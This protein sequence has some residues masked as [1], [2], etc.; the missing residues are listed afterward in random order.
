MERLN[1][2]NAAQLP[3]SVRRPR[4]DMAALQIGMAHIGAGAFHRCHQAEYTDDMLE[5]SFGPWGVLGVNLRPPRLAEILSPQDN[6]YT[7]TLK[8][9][10]VAETRLIG[11]VRRVLDVETPAEAGMAIAALSAPQIGV[12]TLTLTERGYCHIPA[13]GDLDTANPDVRN[14]LETPAQ[15][16]SALG[17]LAAV[18]ERRRAIAAPALTIISCDNLPANGRLLHRVLMQFIAPRGPALSRWIDDHV[19]FP[20]AMV[21]RIVPATSSDDLEANAAHLGMLDQAAVFGEPF[22]QWVIEDRFAGVKPPWHL[23]G[24]Q[25]VADVEPYELIKMRVL[26]AAQSTLSHLGP[27][28]G[29]TFSFEAAADPALAE[30][31]RRMLVEESAQT[32]PQLP[33][34]AIPPYIRTS[35][36]RISNTAIRHRCHQI[37]TDGSQKI[38]QRLVNPLRELSQRGKPAPRLTLAVAAWIAYVLAGA[39]AFGAR[40]TPSDP[41]AEQLIALGDGCHGDL[42]ALSEKIV[43]I[44]AI[45]G[46]VPP[47]PDLPAQI[48]RHLSGIFTGDPRRYL[49]SV[50][51]P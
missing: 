35:F 31:V 6:L 5:A 3:A 4:Y 8:S 2:Q 47:A 12:I 7:R 20:C 11:C 29:H 25:L 14:D 24:A 42:S 1:A 41:F 40:W 23:A 26:N 19:T 16:R 38:V 34:M 39:P 18:L 51:G 22:R 28:L 43:G 33:D 50:I 15:P 37:G 49:A 17:V 36:E 9:G 13:T 46:K 21:D 30:L 32:L 44:T 48:A 27:F 10:S 45:F